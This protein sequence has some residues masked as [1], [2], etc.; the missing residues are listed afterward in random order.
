VDPAHAGATGVSRA[1][2]R[3]RAPRPR[4]GKL[5][6][7]IE[8]RIPGSDKLRFIEVK[9]RVSDAVTITV[10]RNE[11]QQPSWSFS[12]GDDH[13]GVVRRATRDDRSPVGRGQSLRATRGEP[14]GRHTHRAVTGQG[15][16][17]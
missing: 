10:T 15:E 12:D 5:G 11:I 7:D 3:L 4:T 13:L 14:D 8:S 1:P 9:G 2:S 17:T 6:Y 16:N